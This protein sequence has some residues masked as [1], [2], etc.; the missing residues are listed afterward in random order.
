MAVGVQRLD[1]A[2]V[3]ETGLHRFHALPV[4]DE[5]TRVVVAQRVKPGPGPR[6]C[7]PAGRRP[8]MT[9]WCIRR[10][11]S[12]P[13]NV[14]GHH[15]VGLFDPGDD[16]GSNSD[17]RRRKPSAV[18]DRGDQRHGVRVAGAVKAFPAAPGF[19]WNG[20]RRAERGKGSGTES[21]CRGWPAVPLTRRRPPHPLDTRRA[22]CVNSACA[23][24]RRVTQPE[25]R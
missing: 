24:P 22:W 13:A 23:P 1:R 2:G 8:H 10:W 12:T 6:N 17:D 9:C 7:S 3:A 16:N 5:Q 14:V 21:R 15:D 4:S 19:P 20:S 18:R 11:R 25:S